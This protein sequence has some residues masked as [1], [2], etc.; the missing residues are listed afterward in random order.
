MNL[1][2]SIKPAFMKERN[3][4]E[5]SPFSHMFNFRKIWRKAVFMTAVSAILP[6][7][8][9][10]AVDYNL[11]QQSAKSEVISRASRIVSNTKRSISYFLS[12]RQAALDFIIHDNRAERLTDR[13]RLNE[14]LQNLKA[15]FG[16]I[17]DI[18]LIDHQGRQI[19]YIGEYDLEGKNYSGQKWFLEV[20]DRGVYVSDVFLGFR[21]LPHLVIAV[22]YTLSDG[23]YYI[24]RASVDTAQ[25]TE[26][27]SNLEMVE[28]SDAF[29]INQE[30]TL[31]TPSRSHGKVLE[32]IN[33]DVPPYAQE[34]AILQQSDSKGEELIIGYAYIQ[35][36]PFILM[37][38]KQKG[39][40]MRP[41]RK[42]RIQILGFLMIGVVFI[43]ITIIGFA[44]YMVNNMYYADQKRLM[45]LHQMEYSNKLAS[46]GRLAAGV[47]HEI[48]NPLA[49]INEKAGFIKD[50]FTYKNEY[51]NDQKLIDCVN[52]ILSSVERGGRITHRLLGFARHMDAKIEK[53]NLKNVITDV[54][55]FLAKEAEYRSIDIKLD[56]S[57]AI[58][59]FETDRG[60][61]QQ[62][63]LNLI[64]NAFAA[65]QDGG[66]IEI[67]AN[68]VGADQVAIVCADQG[69]GISAENLKHV[70]EPFFSTR[71]N[72]GG[73]GLGL[74]ITYGL[75]KELGG[76]IDVK[77][78]A[79][80]GTRFTILLPLKMKP[81]EENRQCVSY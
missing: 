8:V 1:L 41:W 74:S 75:V 14:I 79:G 54:L 12:V 52:S 3:V 73:T 45:A 50:L 71:A 55:G 58:E 31:Q 51:K 2:N 53:I 30:G 78:E 5:G 46:I 59:P 68:P 69:C 28:Q 25:F 40:L 47:A 24:L 33:L 67:S 48:N 81:S 56:I 23:F 7:V 61:L 22:K 27:L 36:T 34:T 6:L 21:N 4:A 80:K 13:R 38:I 49:I 64:N 60:K 77:S 57:D 26:L 10:T 18:G 65:V 39:E 15:S 20:L 44:T 19:A 43:L 70:F 66:R 11:T 16:G 29:I 32:K 72:V 37:V 35:N 63:L 76:T 9:I 17:S 42:T 62:I